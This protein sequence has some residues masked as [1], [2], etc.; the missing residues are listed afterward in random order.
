MQ[1]LAEFYA[2]EPLE[3]AENFR[4]HQRKQGESVKDFIAALHKLSVHC[5]FCNYLKTTL[6]NQLVFGL[7]SHRA[8]SRLLETRDL[9]LEKAVTVATA[10]ELSEKDARGTAATSRNGGRR[11]RRYKGS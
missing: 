9:N 3:I 7:S 11:I 6:R 1:N 10:M 4:F 2:P 8:Q 5:N